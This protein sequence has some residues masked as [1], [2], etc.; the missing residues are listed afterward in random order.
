MKYTIL[1]RLITNVTKAGGRKN[2]KHIEEVAYELEGK[3]Y[4]D[5]CIIHKRELGY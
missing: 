1:R 4:C 5:L 3:T 2:L